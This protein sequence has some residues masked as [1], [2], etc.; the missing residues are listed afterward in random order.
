[1][2]DPYEVLGVPRDA[3]E[4]RIKDEYR[5]LARKHHPDVNPGN[6]AAEDR[7][8]DIQAAYDVLSDPEKR[9]QYDQGGAAAFEGGSGP[10][11][12]SRPG[13]FG[14]P[15]FEDIFGQGSLN[16]ILAGLFGGGGPGRQAEPRRGE[17][18]QAAIEVSLED[19]LGGGE[20]HALVATVPAPVEGCRVIGRVLEGA[21]VTLDGRPV[22]AGWEHFA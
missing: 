19:V 2:K 5:K 17:D 9:R 3:D 13:G 12:G 14:F 4:K 20:D 18:I 8:K 10:R 1:M 7:F 22:S 6:K 21:G 11:P 16:E 15:S